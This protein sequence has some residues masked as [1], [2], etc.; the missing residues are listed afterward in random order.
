[1]TRAARKAAYAAAR[2]ERDTRPTAR[3]W[4]RPGGGH[5]AWV[6]PP[7]EYRGTTVQVCGLWPFSAGSG[8][9][10]DGVPLGQHQLTGS[11]VCGD[12]IMWFLAGRILNPSAF[13]LGRPG[14]GKSTLVRR[15]VNVS[16]AFGVIPLV[17]ADLKPDYPDL[18]AALGGQVIE[19]GRGRGHVNPLDP[20]PLATEVHRLPAETRRRVEAEQ[21]GRALNVLTGLCELVRGGTLSDR[22][23][24]M[25]TAALRVV[26]ADAAAGDEVTGGAGATAHRRPPLIADVVR[27]ITDRHPRVRAMSLDRG[28]NN[29]YDDATELL[30]ASLMALGEDGQFGDTFSRHTTTPMLL[31][32]PV[33]FDVSAIDTAEIKLQAAVQLVCWSYGQSAVSAAK[34]LADSGLRE[35]AVYL[36]VMDELW[37]T[38]KASPE[39]VDRVDELTRLNRQKVLG[40]VLITHTMND[41]KLSD[42][43]ATLKAW[44]FVERS[45]MVFLGGLA[46]AEMGNLRE[47]FAMSDAETSLISDWSAEGGFSAEDGRRAAPPGQGKFLLKVGKKPG[48]PFEVVLTTVEAGV[49][50]TNKGWAQARTRHHGS[51]PATAEVGGA[52]QGGSGP[53]AGGAW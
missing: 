3:G 5:V 11:T 4:R 41:L 21:L 23:Q 32:R 1:M 9:P 24:S 39:M 30:R 48:T 31:D 49:N 2:A 25:L 28:E 10:T 26:Y 44:G 47:V 34:E 40:Q 16:A 8:T 18:I 14:L 19:V 17:L 12:P 38:L 45:E 33:V 13:V 29:R 15:I 35:R 7:P 37:R 22:E 42:Q 20:G 6:E 50:D 27:V 36:M 46:D 43:A 52:D 51:R 53:A